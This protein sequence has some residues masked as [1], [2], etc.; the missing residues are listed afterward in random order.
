MADWYQKQDALIVFCDALNFFGWTIYGYKE[1]RSD[2]QTDYFDPERW[3]GIAVKNGYIL[4][5]ENNCGGSISGN[6]IERSYNQSATKQVNKLIR[7]NKLLENLANN[8]AAKKG[9]KDNAL[10]MIDKNLEKIKKLNNEYYLEITSNNPFPSNLPEVQYQKNP[11]GATWHI[12]KNGKIILKGKNFYKFSRL[13]LFSKGKIIFKEFNNNIF[14]DYEVYTHDTWKK[15][16]DQ[17]VEDKK[18]DIEIYDEFMKFLSKLEEAVDLKIGDGELSEL[19]EVIKVDKEVYYIPKITKKRTDY[20]ICDDK[21]SNFRGIQKYLVYKVSDKTITKLTSKWIEFKDESLRTYKR[22][23]NSRTKA[24]TL[25]AE[26]EDF[27]NGDVH[28]VELVEKIKYV[29]KTYWVK[30]KSSRAKK[31]TSN[32]KNKKKVEST[33]KE[34]SEKKPQEAKISTSVE[35]TSM[36]FEKIINDGTIEEKIHTKTKE[37]YNLLV[38]PHLGKNFKEFCIY[39][40]KNKLGYYVPFAKGFYIFS[41]NENIA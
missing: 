9:E 26:Q 39:L 35:N 40:S 14:F 16:Y 25:W 23:P 36:D 41:L 31:T 7:Q 29:E 6:Y 33:V 17:F 13:N 27:D 34:V 2:S 37:K 19:E 12:E 28:Y 18:Y 8:E 1:N 11:R 15:Y 38:V 22:E 32:S 21:W 30:K 24:K 4:V 5:M 3:D 20:I 10:S